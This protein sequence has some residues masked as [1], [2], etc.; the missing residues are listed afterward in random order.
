[1]TG[2]GSDGV[3]DM[4]AVSRE[5]G[6]TLGQDESSCTVYGMPRACARSGVLQRVVTLL[7]IPD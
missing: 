1:M 7:Q 5:G 6:V 3:L 2:V 4:Q